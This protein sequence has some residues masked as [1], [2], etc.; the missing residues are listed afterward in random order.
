MAIPAELSIT[1]LAKVL[2][3]PRHTVEHR[4]EVGT[5]PSY[6]TGPSKNSKRVVNIETLRSSF[7]ELY[8]AVVMRSEDD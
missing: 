1:Q 3:L 5:I 4:V 7:P 6:K 2:G 8:E